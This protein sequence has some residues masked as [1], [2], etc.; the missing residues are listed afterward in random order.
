MQLRKRSHRT[1]TSLDEPIGEKQEH[2]IAELLADQRPTPEDEC[3]NYELRARLKELASQLSP[4]LRKAFQLRDLDGLTTREAA[5]ILGVAEGTV[6]AQ[7][8][9]AR[10]KLRRLIGRT[11]RTQPHL[12]RTYATPRISEK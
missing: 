4:S 11:P 1:L 10:A 8:A 6:K 9:R 3:R 2:T 7:L 12:R 5:H